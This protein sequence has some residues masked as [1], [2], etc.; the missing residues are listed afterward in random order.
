[1]GYNM[2]CPASPSFQRPDLMT[3]TNLVQPAGGSVQLRC[4]ATGNPSPE[5]SWY[6]DGDMVDQRLL[7]IGFAAGMSVVDGERIAVS[8]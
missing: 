2:I 5:I 1:M 7:D 3:E 8:I 4:R 6:K